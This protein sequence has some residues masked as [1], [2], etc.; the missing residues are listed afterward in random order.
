MLFI[1]LK[2]LDV[3]SC[4]IIPKIIVVNFTILFITKSSYV[5]K[6]KILYLNCSNRPTKVYENTRE[7]DISMINNVA[8]FTV[9]LIRKNEY[10]CQPE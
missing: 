7:L 3:C 6:K 4:Y 8:C 10:H 5:S 2:F 9:E 1:L